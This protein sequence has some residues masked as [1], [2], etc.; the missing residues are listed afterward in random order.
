MKKMVV[1]GG[2]ISGLG[3]ARLGAQLGYSVF[4]SD[5]RTISEGDKRSL[6]EWGVE[7]EEGGHG[8][9]AW[10]S[11]DLAVKSPGVPNDAPVVTKLVEAGCR[12][13]SE[14]EFAARHT[15]AKIAAVS[16]TNGKTTTVSLL[17]HILDKAGYDYALGGN[18]GKSF[19][20][21]VAEKSR[22]YYVL[23]VSSFQLDDSPEFRPHISVLL[24]ITPDHL[25]RYGSMKAY[26]DSK[27]LITANQG[28][29]DHFI[30]VDDDP[31][32]HREVARRRLTPRT[33]P[34]TIRRKV[35]D[36]AYVQNDTLTIHLTDKPDFD[37]SI[38]ELA[39]QGN[40][41]AYNSMAAAMAAR[42]LDVRKEIIRESLMDFRNI[43]H[44]LES[45]AQVH[46]IEFINDSKATNVNSTWYALETVRA[47]IVWI[48]GGVDKG[49]DYTMLEDLVRAKVKA[50]ICLGKDN[51]KLRNFFGG[52]V[53][54]IA[55]ADS[56]EKAVSLAYG[57]A[58]K[59]D[60]VLLSPACASFDL[61][62]NYEDRGRKFKTAVRML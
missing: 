5:S 25:D 40:H 59:G 53:A 17:A 21:L 16:G 22:D 37:M 32:L 56:A 7:F 12:P 24:N 13:I 9:R 43:E 62:E 36:G 14:I 55:E 27:F 3:A 60:T 23:E 6:R 19:A 1:I 42:L 49:N 39:L 15:D 4:L 48:V 52:I 61:F 28:P 51:R 45:V 58:N 47:P 38:Y 54:D 8:E 29:D 30:Y 34:I 41:N 57:F 35:E 50:I 44:R 20:A 33:Y 18:V 2:G 46:G 26:T 31:V 10:D 11:P